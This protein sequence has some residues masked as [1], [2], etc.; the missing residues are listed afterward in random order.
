MIS[1]PATA[2]SSAPFLC[3][4]RVRVTRLFKLGGALRPA[5]G[6]VESS[7]TLA[8]G[9]RVY[10]PAELPCARCDTCRSGLRTHCP[11]RRRDL[12][13][14]GSFDG[15]IE[16][17]GRALLG[18]PSDLGDDA[19]AFAG[20]VARAIH[21]GQRLHIEGRAY[22][23]VLGDSA[24]ALIAAQLL[25]R[26]NA[27][28]RCLGE[29]PELYSLCEKWGIAH[30][31]IDEVGRRGDQDAVIDCT[32]TR[33]GFDLATRLV[34]PRGR[35]V[36][37]PERFGAAP[38]VLEA[39]PVVRLELDVFGVRAGDEAEALHALAGRRVEVASLVGRRARLGDAAGAPESGGLRTLIEG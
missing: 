16:A 36:L 21:A 11:H 24:I 8:P 35:L 25:V 30:R 14:P 5:V 34:R 20:E 23:T 12:L 27:T 6:L 37:M 39:E 19:A 33:E 22:V 18:V 32:G 4:T 38:P 7:E 3:D 1:T 31:H 26:M 2:R 29:H 15:F 10:L 28:V 17:P 13:D 9:S